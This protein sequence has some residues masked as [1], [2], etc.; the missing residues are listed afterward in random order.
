MTV[1]LQDVAMFFGLGIRGCPVIGSAVADGWRGRV[2]QL[3][4]TPP[5]AAQGEEVRRGRVSGVPLRWLRETFAQCPEHT[6]EGTIMYYCRAW[7]LSLFGFVLFP[8][9]TGDSASW[10]YIHCLWDWDEAGTCMSIQ[11]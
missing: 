11:W 6:D 1:T 4:G 2:E 10:M 7:V 8:D 5:P 3:L 9:A